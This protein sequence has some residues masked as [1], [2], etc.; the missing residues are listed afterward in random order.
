MSTSRRTFLTPALVSLAALVLAACGGPPESD[1]AAAPGSADYPVEAT[2]CGFTSTIEQKPSRVVTMNQGATELV[3]ALGAEDQLVGTAYLDDQVPAKWAKA[4]ESVPVLSKEYPDHETL[5]TAEPDFVYGSYS[6]AFERKN[7]GTPTDLQELGIGSYTSPF[8]CGENEP[9]VDVSFE[10]VWDEVEVVADVLGVPDRAAKIRSDQRSALA[11]L[12]QQD[13]GAGTTVF[14][15]DSG[16]K[17]AFAGTGEGGPQLILDAVGATNVF[18][19]VEGGWADVSWERVVKADPDVIVLAD[20][21]WSSADDKIAL[22]K[23]DPALRDLKAVRDEQFVVLPFSETTPGV[24]LADGA[25]A[26]A[27]GLAELGRG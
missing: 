13:V 11:A 17:A 7:A 21:D 4:Y 27:A 23:K 10:S 9:S 15:F 22:L 19:D 8:G 5:L 12:A 14:W 1:A 25:R 24:R 26:V 16:D 20:A 18:A 3:L 2:S 6:S